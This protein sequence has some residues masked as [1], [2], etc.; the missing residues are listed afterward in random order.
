NKFELF[1]ST[2]PNEP[3]TRSA[4]NSNA[5]S[6][7]SPTPSRAPRER[8]SPNPQTP[9]LSNGR[10]M[11]ILIVDDDKLSL[12]MLEHALRQDGHEVHAARSG[13]KALRALDSGAA[14]LVIS[15]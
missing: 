8:R 6:P 13:A 15:D 9:M 3:S 4:P 1:S 2:P 10:P 7:T 11:R 5:A 14:R 12:S